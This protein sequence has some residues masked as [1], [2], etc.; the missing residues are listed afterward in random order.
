MCL[1]ILALASCKNDDDNGPATL[2]GTWKLTR[3]QGGIAGVDE[4]FPSGV[5][6]WT[7]HLD[8]QT[9]TVVNNLTPESANDFFESGTYSFQARSTGANSTCGASMSIDDI[10]FGCMSQSGNTLKF[11]QQATDGFLVTLKR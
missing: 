10:D 6:T 1:V 8:T 11:D 2:E 7:F 3:V 4:R 9:V 5:I